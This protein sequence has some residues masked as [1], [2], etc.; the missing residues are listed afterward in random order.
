MV[1]L[2][3]FWGGKVDVAKLQMVLAAILKLC[4][5]FFVCLFVLFWFCFCFVFVLLFCFV[6]VLFCCFVFV[7]FCIL[8]FKSTLTATKISTQTSF[9]NLSYVY[10]VGFIMFIQSHTCQQMR[11]APGGKHVK[12][13]KRRLQNILRFRPDARKMILGS[14]GTSP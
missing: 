4:I 1:F 10:E 2:F 6:F 3:F 5:R 9:G 14:L 11:R 7:F 13:I 12:S 8:V